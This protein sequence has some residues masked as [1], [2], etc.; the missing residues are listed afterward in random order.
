MSRGALFCSHSNL[1]K[2]TC[3]SVSSC[4]TPTETG[5]NKKQRHQTGHL[6]ALSD[7]GRAGRALPAFFPLS[8]LL[9]L[10][11]WPLS[12]EHAQVL[13]LLT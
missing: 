7:H 13:F 2:I 11:N 3:L 8:Q 9:R 1:G 4:L 6:L 5:V 10:L 12:H